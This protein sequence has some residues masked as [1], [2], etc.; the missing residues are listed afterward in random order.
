MTMTYDAF[1]TAYTK[2][3]ARLLLGNRKL[4]A[5]V[6]LTGGGRLDLERQDQ[7]R[8]E[9]TSKGNRCAPP[10]IRPRRGW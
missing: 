7:A 1:E 5:G 10:G 2:A 9:G 3:V 8:P 6:V 4:K